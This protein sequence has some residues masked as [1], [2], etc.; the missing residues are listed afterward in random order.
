MWA[1]CRQYDATTDTLGLIIHRLPLPKPMCH[2]IRKQWGFTSEPGWHL[3]ETRDPQFE[4]GE[5]VVSVAVAVGVNQLQ[6]R[7]GEVDDKLR[8]RRSPCEP[9]A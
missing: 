8:T 1:A 5:L 2:A 6:E 3:L 7:L 9:G 4:E